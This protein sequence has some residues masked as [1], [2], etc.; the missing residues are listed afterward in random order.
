MSTEKLIGKQNKLS[1][2]I[3]KAINKINPGILIDTRKI[4]PLL[5]KQCIGNDCLSFSPNFGI[6]IISWEESLKIK[7]KFLENADNVENWMEE[8]FDDNWELNSEI[9]TPRLNSLD[10]TT[11]IFSYKPLDNTFG[12]CISLGKK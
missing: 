12:R 2:R 1:K 3:N 9:I 11:Y 4:C 10:E 5:G 6:N 7:Q 8:L